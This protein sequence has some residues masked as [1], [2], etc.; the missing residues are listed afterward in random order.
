MKQMPYELGSGRST[1]PSAPEIKLHYERLA[2]DLCGPLTNC[3]ASAREHNAV[4]SHITSQGFSSLA[5]CSLP[6]CLPLTRL[7]RHLEAWLAS[8][9]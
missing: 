8:D 2:S 4:V 3:D 9:V 6:S 5:L 7:S 1:A